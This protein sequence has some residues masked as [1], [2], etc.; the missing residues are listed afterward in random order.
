MN[1]FYRIWRITIDQSIK[2]QSI[3][4][5]DVL[6]ATKDL[7]SF[8]P[9]INYELVCCINEIHCRTIRSVAWSPRGNILAQSSF[10]GSVSILKFNENFNS[11]SIV[12]KLEGH[13][14]EVKSVQWS[15]DG[16]WL[17]TCGRDKTVWIWSYS[18]DEED[19]ECYAIKQE[20]SQDVKCICWH[21]TNSSIFLSASYD[22]TVRVWCYDDDL[23]EWEC[24]Q[25]IRA[26]FN[27]NSEDGMLPGTIWSISF[28]SNLRSQKET[29]I[30]V[31]DE[32]RFQE[33]YFDESVQRWQLIDENKERLC[34][35]SIYSICYKQNHVAL[36][37]SDGFVLIMKRDSECNVS[38][39]IDTDNN[40]N[41]YSKSDS[42]QDITKDNFQNQ[43]KST[44]TKLG[45]WRVVDKINFPSNSDIN[46]VDWVLN[47]TVI[48]ACTDDYNI[49]LITTNL[50]K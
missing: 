45:K 10:D 44:V 41:R 25:T 5:S 9:T 39:I 17:A 8:L 16:H 2:N 14:N 35:G 38:H 21:P 47:G 33:Y 24:V 30:C 26:F 32:G 22:G 31:G 49:H 29:F 34:F 15:P 13:E 46:S 4:Q 6:N 12:T 20:H 7:H 11:F 43:S 36:A 23:D 37:C 19:F 27:V 40:T 48:A 42:Y 3:C 28:S 1:Y 18:N 50:F